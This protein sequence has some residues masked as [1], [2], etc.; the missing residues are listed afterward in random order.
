MV[1]IFIGVILIALGIMGLSQDWPTS[2]IFLCVFSSVAFSAIGAMMVAAGI[3]TEGSRSSV[4]VS[5]GRD[6]TVDILRGFAI[7]TMD[8]ANLAP[9]ALLEP[10]PFLFRF[11][12][13]FAAPIF[14]TL[15]GMMVVHT[16][17]KKGYGFGYF[18]IRGLGLIVVGALIEI[19]GTLTYPFMIVDVLYLI[20]LS[21]PI[22]YAFQFCSKATRWF[23]MICL[24]L[25]TPLLQKMLGYTSYPTSYYLWGAPIVNVPDPTSVL[26]HW[27]IDG[28]F[29]IFPWLGFALFGSNLGD[30][31]W[32]KKTGIS[33]G[34]GQ[35]TLW[36]VCILV[37]GSILWMLYPGSLLVR[38]GY[39]ELFYPPTL[40][41]I[42]TTLGLILL[43][44]S[45]VDRD[46]A[47]F[48]FA[49]FRLLGESSLAL[50]VLHLILIH[51][52]FALLMVPEPFGWFVFAYIVLMSLLFAA[53]YCLRYLKTQWKDRPVICR[54]LLSG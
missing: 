36:G 18:L 52:V 14:I 21:L 47:T 51:W 23:F 4:W 5:E 41:Y 12:G 34:H 27:I 11:Y 30:L 48:L 19:I 26:N 38:A 32:G 2:S 31:R 16:T 42:T 1:D 40:G 10:H 39:S 9:I 44:F 43:L 28:F 45:L 15:A 54:F 8:A 29:P 6:V 17:R 53:A 24:F 25:M 33:F 7:F 13:T 20:G 46:P 49:P 37:V 35:A 22:V 3:R 50:Y